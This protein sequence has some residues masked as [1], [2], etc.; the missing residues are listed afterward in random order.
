MAR[1]QKAQN[2]KWDIQGGNYRAPKRGPR[3]SGSAWKVVDEDAALARLRPPEFLWDDDPIG[4]I[5]R[6]SQYRNDDGSRR[7][8]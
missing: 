4:L 2:S 3:P 8:I 6:W 5:S 7:W 1:R